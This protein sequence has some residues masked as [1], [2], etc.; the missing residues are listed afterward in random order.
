MRGDAT[1]SISKGTLAFNRFRLELFVSNPSFDYSYVL[2]LKYRQW[3]KLSRRIWQDQPGATIVSTN[4]TTAGY[5][6]VLDLSVENDS[7]KTVHYQTRPFSMGYMYSHLHRI[8]AMV[9]AELENSS[10][11]LT[12]ALYGSD[13]LQDW[14]LLAYAY[15]SGTTTTE[16]NVT[17]N[18]PLKLSQLRTTSSSRS[19]RYYTVTVGG[20][21]NT[22]KDIDLGPVVVDYEPVI[23]RI[24]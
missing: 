15:R 20:I 10:Q 21:I 12:A 7:V 17:T 8:V 18:T 1:N 9:R 23:R 22:A 4:G 6:T 14:N 13:N 11:N 5:I 2:S 16:D 19:W 3:Y 24:G